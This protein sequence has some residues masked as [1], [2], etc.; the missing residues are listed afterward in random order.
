R[1]ADGPQP[2]LLGLAEAGDGI[3]GACATQ[4]GARGDDEDI[5][6][7]VVVLEGRVPGVGKGGEVVGDVQRDRLRR[8]G[9]HA[10]ASDGRRK[11]SSAYERALQPA[12]ACVSSPKSMRE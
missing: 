12:I 9:G 5:A 1:Q 3:P 4:D 2:G 10:C 7:Q 8:G 6:Q 11:V